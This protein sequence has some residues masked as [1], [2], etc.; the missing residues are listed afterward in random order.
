MTTA[1]NKTLFFSGKYFW[2]I[3]DSGAGEP[4]KIK[5]EFPELEENL[6]AA[7]TLHTSQDKMTFLFIKG[8][9]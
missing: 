1:D 8:A 3:G 7:V 6:D 5:D 4:Q 9:L 2:E